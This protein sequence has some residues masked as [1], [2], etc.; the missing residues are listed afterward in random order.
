MHHFAWR[1][2][3]LMI[4]LTYSANDVVAQLSFAE[5]L[6]VVAE[7]REYEKYAFEYSMFVTSYKP[8]TRTPGLTVHQ[9]GNIA[10]IPKEG[11]WMVRR[12]EHV[13]ERGERKPDHNRVAIRNEESDSGDESDSVREPDPVGEAVSSEGVPATD[14][15][16]SVTAN[17]HM[18]SLYQNGALH[19]AYSGWNSFKSQQL[20][21]PLRFPVKP[22]DFRVLGLAVGGDLY[23][24]RSLEDVLQAW[25]P[26]AD[27]YPPGKYQN[28]DGDTL[29]HYP[30]GRRYS[31]TLNLTKGS[32]FTHHRR[33]RG[34]KILG[35]TVD[36]VESEATLRLVYRDGDWL[37]E[38]YK[39]NS[40]QGVMEVFFTWLPTD[41]LSADQFT[42][43]Y[44]AEV[45]RVDEQRERKR[46]EAEAKQL[47]E[48][49][50][51][52]T[53]ENGS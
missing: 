38:Y 6:K 14:S 45:K 33:T 22:F 40:V 52:E 9:E 44:L 3:C 7:E 29:V 20:E 37:P 19:T 53:R 34:R 48:Q 50:L 8:G 4:F 5:A 16:I 46:L 18:Y 25:E 21:A 42:L 13:L 15:Q 41:D 17:K 10:G 27:E 43:D 31:Y 1:A 32:W 12:I 2:L 35:E 36:A 49:K 11:L 24:N 28:I 30:A 51:K 26:I 47:L 39:G 23:T